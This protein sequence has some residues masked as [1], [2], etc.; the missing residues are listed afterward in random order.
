MQRANLHPRT[1]FRHA[2]YAR[3]A[4]CQA[5]DFFVSSLFFMILSIASAIA[6]AVAGIGLAQFFSGH[7]L[8]AKA[9]GSV[10]KTSS[11][12]VYASLGLS[13]VTS[14]KGGIV[15]YREVTDEQ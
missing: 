15:L 8:F 7:P 13:G 11:L 3:P 2:M 9:A 12:F 5:Y 14:F 1:W 10:L 4:E 6:V